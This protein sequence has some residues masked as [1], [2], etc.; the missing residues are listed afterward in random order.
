MLEEFKEYRGTPSVPIKYVI[1]CVTPADVG[2]VSELYSEVFARPPWSFSLLRAELRAFIE[3]SLKQAD[4]AGVVADV[5]TSI[6]GVSWGHALTEDTSFQPHLE[7]IPFPLLRDVGGKGVNPFYA[8]VTAVREPHRRQHV[9]TGLVRDR[10]LEAINLGFSQS[11]FRTK[12]A[13]MVHLYERL[14]GPGNVV[15]L[16]ADPMFP[17]RQWYRVNLAVIH[18]RLHR[19]PFA[20]STAKLGRR[21]WLG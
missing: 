21:E 16:F 7:K 1:R 4:F 11:V 3:G 15:R 19:T 2:P 14:F 8:A 10:S 12:N 17:D 13:A 6:V 5:G 9:A 18:E 20:N